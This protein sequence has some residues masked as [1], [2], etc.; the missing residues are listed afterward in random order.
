MLIKTLVV[1]HLGT[2]CYVV[3]DE[4]SLLCAVIDPG[5]ESGTILDYMED[6]HLQCKAIMLTH[7][8]FDHTGAVR[9]LMEETGAP[10]HMHLADCG[11]GHHRFDAPDGTYFYDDG[12]CVNVGALEFHVIA[13]PGHTPGGVTL[14]CG[15]ALFTGDTLFRDSCGRTDLPGG[16]MPTQLRSLKRLAQIE[17]EFD[18]YPGHMEPSTLDRERRFN[19]YMV[20]AMNK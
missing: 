19:Y 17:G 13:T 11:S 10:L 6:N 3:T 2:N 1:G 20:A 15:D 9:A 14:Q 12:D 8:H 16:D 5:D 18:V 4:D 7:G